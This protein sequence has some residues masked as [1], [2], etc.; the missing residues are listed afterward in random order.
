[1]AKEGGSVTGRRQLACG[2]AAADCGRI[3]DA[4]DAVAAEEVRRA[5]RLDVG[6]DNH[7]T[8]TR[9]ADDAGATIELGGAKWGS[10]HEAASGVSDLGQIVMPRARSTAARP[11]RVLFPPLAML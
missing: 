6:H 10:A 3:G 2:D 7:G 1:M 8:V 5:A 11:L 9:A 4:L